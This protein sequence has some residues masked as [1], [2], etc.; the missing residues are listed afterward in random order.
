M[1]IDARVTKSIMKTLEDGRQGFEKAAERLESSDEA[2]LARQFRTFATQ[3]A[4]FSSAL[5]TMAKQYGDDID[6][7]G[8]VAGALHRGWLTVKDALSGSDAS[9]VLEAAEQGEDHAVEQYEKGLKED[10]SDGLR[11]VLERQFTEVKAAHDTVRNL[12]DSR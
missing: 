11:T 6:E 5:E 4:E 2:E 8:S 10:I 1:S 3:R 9:G 7:D 12:R